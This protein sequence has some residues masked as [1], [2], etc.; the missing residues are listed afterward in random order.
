MGQ[1]D[2]DGVTRGSVGLR[3][4]DDSDGVTRGPCMAPGPL[5]CCDTRSHTQYTPTNQP[6]TSPRVP[7]AA[8]TSLEADVVERWTAPDQAGAVTAGAAE[9]GGCEWCVRRLNP[10]TRPPLLPHTRRRAE[11]TERC[12]GGNTTPHPTPL[13]RKRAHTQQ[14]DR[15]AC[16]LTP[17]PLPSPPHLPSPAA[18]AELALLALIRVDASIEREGSN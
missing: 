10:V 17:L 6:N 2:S 9:G 13:L 14:R 16:L 18:A 8:L 4:S 7:D 11:K 1:V 3:S 5:A 12:C 15:R